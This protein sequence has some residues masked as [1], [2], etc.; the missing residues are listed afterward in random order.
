MITLQSRN[1]K[2][3]VEVGKLVFSLLLGRDT[4]IVTFVI[5]FGCLIDCLTGSDPPETQPWPHDNPRSNKIG[6]LAEET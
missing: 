4:I 5:G 1:S 2:F 6:T 3:V